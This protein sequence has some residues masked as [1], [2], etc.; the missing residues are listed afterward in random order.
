MSD[1]PNVG[2]AAI[3]SPRAC[4]ISGDAALIEKWIET[5]TREGVFSRA[6]NVDVAS[7]SSHMDEPAR[8]LGVELAGL[9]ASDVNAVRFIRNGIPYAGRE[10]GWRLLG[11]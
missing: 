2:V 4:V 5:F 8:V 9:H 10:V 7:H 3:N 1:T 11:A 6:V